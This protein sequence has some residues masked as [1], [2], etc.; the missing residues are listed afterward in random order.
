VRYVIDPGR[1]TRVLLVDGWH[2]IHA[3]SF[4]VLHGRR[5]TFVEVRVG[6]DA[7]YRV[8]GPLTSIL[9]TAEDIT[10]RRVA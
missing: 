7:R 3:R 10:P 5:F 9:A 4:E 6:T 2:D 1:V 8:S